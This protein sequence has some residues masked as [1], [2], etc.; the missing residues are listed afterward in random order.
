MSEQSIY[1]HVTLKDYSGYSF[2][3]RL[4]KENQRRRRRRRKH[5][6]ESK[7][8]AKR[9]WGPHES[10]LLRSSSRA[11]SQAAGGP[12]QSCFS[13]PHVRVDAPR[14]RRSPQLVYILF[15]PS[16]RN[17]RRATLTIALVTSARAVIHTYIYGQYIYTDAGEAGNRLDGGGRVAS[18]AEIMR[19]SRGT[20]L[21]LCTM[22]NYLVSLNRFVM[23]H[24]TRVSPLG[25]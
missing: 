7:T 22:M 14:R 25:F 13:H 17:P 5:D 16:S 23:N 19:G 4:K 21:V 15:V 24:S 6:G 8:V 18:K 1:R 20:I 11:E 9:R 12:F 2:F 3:A 10:L